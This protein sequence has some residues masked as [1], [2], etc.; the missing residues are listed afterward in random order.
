ML[1]FLDVV[2]RE[3]NAADTR[4]E[5]GGREPVAPNLFTPL[6]NGWRLVASF[7]EA[8]KE[9][10]EELKVKLE[11]LAETFADMLDEVSARDS[12]RP[13]PS[14]PA[15]RLQDELES[16]VIRARALECAIID[17]KTPYVWGSSFAHNPREDLDWARDAAKAAHGARELGVDAAA[18]L[19]LE[20]HRAEEQLEEGGFGERAQRL[21]VDL[22]AVRNIAITR[23]AEQWQRSLLLAEAM[24]RVRDDGGEGTYQAE[25][26][27]VW[28][29]ARRFAQVYWLVLAFDGPFSQLHAEAAMLHALP[30]IERLVLALPPVD[31]PPAK[32][33]VIRLPR[34]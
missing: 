21:L 25:L 6:A 18:L 7:D 16:L 9:K 14:T 33:R 8:P 4:I 3:L 30:M 28:V 32:A 20:P 13:P 27:D 12:Y 15:G 24:V 5:I 17:V 31:P 2:R 29:L 19:E 23:K 26:E 34:R 22:T 10:P 11:A 1:R